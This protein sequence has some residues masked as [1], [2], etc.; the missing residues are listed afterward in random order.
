M[1]QNVSFLIHFAW[2]HSKSVLFFALALIVCTVGK[3]VIEL[4]IVPVILRK[5]ETEALLTELLRT[6]LV[7]SSA[8]LL[9]TAGKGYVEENI[10]HG[11]LALR[12]ELGSLICDKAATTSYPNMMDTDFCRKRNSADR[13]C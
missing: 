7:F 2:L 1:W 4:L 5:V 6:I 13:A 3:S 10:L 11:R 12:N 8:L 9:V